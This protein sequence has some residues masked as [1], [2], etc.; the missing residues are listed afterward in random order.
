MSR[1]GAGRVRRR[2]PS[3]LRRLFCGALVVGS[4]A[5]AGCGTKH[6]P[7]PK[8][9]GPEVRELRVS[10][11]V[12]VERA[13]NPTGP[14]LCFNAV[15][16]NCNGIIDEGCGVHTGIVQFAIAWDKP[17]AD[18]D[19]NVTDPNGELV[20]VG[21]VAQSGLVK[22]R[23]CPG[24]HDACHGQNM[25]NVYLEEGD[26]VRGQY[27][28][29]IRLEKLGGEDPPV[30]VR[31]GARVGPKTYAAELELGRPEQE[32]ELDVRL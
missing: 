16:D 15:D 10:P 22:E 1:T 8:H 9:A 2:L 26:P 32:Q 11:G 20:E 29:R 27:R 4:V 19:L 14:E 7:A 17:G 21:R 31:F 23:D 28:V 25:E 18:V 12:V 13:C 6:L 24:R 5:L 30:R 3:G